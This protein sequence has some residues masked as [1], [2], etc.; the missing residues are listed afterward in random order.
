[1]CK[2]EIN[3]NK[4]SFSPAKECPAIQH[5]NECCIRNPSPSISCSEIQWKNYLALPLLLLQLDSQDIHSCHH[6]F[7]WWHASWAV[8]AKHAEVY[9]RALR[10]DI[11]IASF[12]Y[13]NSSD[14]RSVVLAA[15]NK[16]SDAYHPCSQACSSG[17]G[18]HKSRNPDSCGVVEEYL[19]SV[20]VH[21][22]SIMS[23]V[24]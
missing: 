24:H 21:T 3:E 15:S 9:I 18:R 20:C 22:S 23:D 8:V 7:H 6:Q 1:M 5:G 14:C 19:C 16:S 13:P 4:S 10:I 17:Q 12:R 2:E 11:W